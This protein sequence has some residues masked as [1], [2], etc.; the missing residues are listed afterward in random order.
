MMPLGI[1]AGV[2][3]AAMMIKPSLFRHYRYWLASA[4]FVLL[5]L[6]LLSLFRP[7][8]GPFA[9]FTLD[10]YISLG[11]TVG[12]AIAGP[13]LWQQILR[14]GS[15]AILAVAVLSPAFAALLAIATG[16]LVT[17]ACIGVL[18][19]ARG[20]GSLFQRKDRDPDAS[21]ELADETAN[22]GEDAITDYDRSEPGAEN[23]ES[24]DHSQRPASRFAM[25]LATAP[26]SIESTMSE[27][28][29]DRASPGPSSMDAPVAELRRREE[30]DMQANTDFDF[31]FSHAAVG[32]A[33]AD[34]DVE[35]YGLGNDLT[36]GYEYDDDDVLQSEDVDDMFEDDIG[37]QFQEIENLTANQP[38]DLPDE[39]PERSGLAV[40]LLGRNREEWSKPPIE[41]L[42]S[43]QDRASPKTRSVRLRRQSVRR[44]QTTT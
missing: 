43:V 18:L 34:A 42:E 35:E 24:A 27:S 16:R 26:L 9:W 7:L 38:S 19:L 22:A 23:E 3:V 36:N 11:G 30:T 17:Y 5:A 21:P 4:L 31:G 13:V 44:S 10:G 20:V 33:V 8:D 40:R 25:A 32:A 29:S 15:L 6:G 12:E 39:D 28:A 41:M 14:L 37:G 2:F 1:W